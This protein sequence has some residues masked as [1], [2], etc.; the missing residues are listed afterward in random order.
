MT[1]VDTGA[2]PVEEIRFGGA[3]AFGVEL[4]TPGEVAE[5]AAAV[6]A[7]PAGLRHGAR[8]VPS[9]STIGE[10]FYLN[11]ERPGYYAACARAENR[12]LYRHFRLVHERVAVFFEQRYG[13]PVVYAEDLAVPG[14]HLFEFPEPGEYPGGGWHVDSLETQV[15]SLVARRAAI[16]AVV[17]FT[18]PFVLPDGGS[19]LDLEA[20]V[21]G[22]P[23]GRRGGGEPVTVPYRAGTMVF[24][25]TELWHRISGSRCRKPGQR[26]VTHQGH[27]VRLGDRWLFFW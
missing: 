22:A 20:D 21:P 3:R 12:L 8:E 14:F 25:E 5:V 10:A 17:N 19:G 7:V 1:T 9:L 15:P 4:F 11:R 2:R 24:T 13:M 27:G 6:A 26:R 18:V 16:T 23:P